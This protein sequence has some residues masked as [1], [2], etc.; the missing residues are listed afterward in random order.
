MDRNT[1]SALTQEER[2]ELEALVELSERISLV[3]AQLSGFWAGRRNDRP[4]P[5]R[6]SG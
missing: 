5:A 2:E 3:C 6:A 1:E 4:A